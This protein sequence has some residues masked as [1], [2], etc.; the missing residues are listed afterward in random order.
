M[1]P[2]LVDNSDIRDLVG[3]VIL[4]LAMVNIFAYEGNISFQLYQ[5]EVLADVMQHNVI[6]NNINRL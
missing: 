4:T 1:P 3:S 6:Y 2:L 5:I